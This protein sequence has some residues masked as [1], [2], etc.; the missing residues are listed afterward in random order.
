MIVPGISHYRVPSIVSRVREVAARH[1]EKPFVR[2]L[3]AGGCATE[4]TFGALCVSMDAWARVYRERCGDGGVCLIFLPQSLAMFAHFFAAMR[5]GC[6]PS[7]MPCPSPKQ[8]PDIYWT[9]HRALLDRLKPSL[10]VTDAA[11]RDQMFANGFEVIGCP[12]L[13]MEDIERSG[14]PLDEMDAPAGGDAV[15]FVQHSS[16]TTGLKKGV[17]LSHRAVLAQVDAYAAALGVGE[18][19]RLVSWLPVYHDMGLIACT[20]MPA[21]LGQTVTVIDP[22]IWVGRPGMLF[23]AI[24]RFRATLTWMPNFAFVHLARTVD[25]RREDYD[26]SSM[27]A[28]I[29]CSEPCQPETFDKFV[30]AFASIG[31]R[32]AQLQVCYALAENV[33]AVTQTNLSREPAILTVDRDQLRRGRIVPARDGRRLIAAGRPLDGVQVTVRD[34]TRILPNDTIGEIYVEGCCLFDGYHG[35]PAASAEWFSDGAY[36]TRDLGFVHEGEFYVL[37]RQDDLIIIHGKNLYATEVEAVMNSIDG[38]KAGRNV[39]FGLYNRVTGSQDLIVVAERDVPATAAPDLCRLLRERI[40]DTLT[41]TPAECLL[42]DGDW[43]VKTTSGKIS[44]GANREKYR[45][46]EGERYMAQ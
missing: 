45:T 24:T 2:Y 31:V 10:I 4:L 27:R 42:V 19:D 33:F 8:H 15:A 37:G 17:A 40:F 38:L 23:D 20:L 1:P 35:S 22:F 12:V 6:V 21:I 7:F 9:S 13:T 41:V 29:N 25:A 26:L 36:C 46:A 16:G 39:A 43:L 34:G 30:A 14:T 28:F 32:P 44:R 11:N 18:E 3:D 5:A